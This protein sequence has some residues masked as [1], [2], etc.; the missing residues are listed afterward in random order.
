MATSGGSPR[1]SL[2]AQTGIETLQHERMYE[3]N[4]NE[5]KPETTASDGPSQAQ[6]A[7]GGDSFAA[8]T[9]LMQSISGGVRQLR[10]PAPEHGGAARVSPQQLMALQR[11]VGNRA[12]Q[13]LLQDAPSRPAFGSAP[14]QRLILPVLQRLAG[15]GA[16]PAAAEQ[17]PT[18]I[19]SDVT[20]PQIRLAAEKG[21]QTSVSALPYR[22]RLQQA[23]G[24]HD[25]SHVKAHLGAEAS[26]SATAMK[27]RAFASG[28][29]VVF[30]GMP[31]LHTVAH[32][33][34]H[35][36]Q[37]QRGIQLSTG[38]GQVGDVYEQQAELVAQR[39]TAGQSVAGLL[40]RMLGAPASPRGTA[41]ASTSASIQRLALVIGNAKAEA[42]HGDT[43]Y[44]SLEM[45]HVETE[46]KE[47]EFYSIP[48]KW[49]DVGMHG[50]YFSTARREARAGK[51]EV[52]G[53]RKSFEPK[54]HQKYLTRLGQD[55]ELRLIAHGSGSKIGGYTPPKLFKLLKSLGL[56]KRHKGDIRIHGCLPAYRPKD[57]AGSSFIEKLYAALHGEGFSNQVLGLRG[58][59]V[60]G[61]DE[62]P[63]SE[64]GK[65]EKN[66]MAISAKNSQIQGNRDRIEGITKKAKGR[67][68]TEE[69]TRKVA[70]LSARVMELEAEVKGLTTQSV[71]RCW[72]K[73]N[74]YSPEKADEKV[75]DADEKVDD[76]DVS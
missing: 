73:A 63:R 8:S 66:A 44:L 20:A 11:G 19:D 15:D 29:H 31:D 57:A 36:L 28:G 61:G 65:T 5:L 69:E 58:I 22:E 64:Y 76:L 42:E 54:A 51:H 9:T 74:P 12:V 60:G 6:A 24:P 33:V 16:S 56:T 41:S 17:M 50:S 72:Y 23:F 26:A 48:D 43:Q 14:V 30:N 18:G 75:D 2:T 27:A 59:I 25:I 62:V 55:E 47:T 71:P 52:Y 4:T 34:T 53:A 40:D 46:E 1:G 35:T 39:V 3:L 7:V 21:L 32:E 38:V 70:M 13:Q 45:A 37:Q 68:M 49:G 67:A 10:T